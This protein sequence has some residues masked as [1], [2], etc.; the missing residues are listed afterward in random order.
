MPQ[1]NGLELYNQ[2]KKQDKDVKICFLTAY[3]AYNEEFSK[4]FPN[5]KA[6][7]F[8]RKPMSLKDLVSHVKSELDL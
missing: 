6:Q 2:I 4:M 5:V 7:C 1:M 8:L 3:E